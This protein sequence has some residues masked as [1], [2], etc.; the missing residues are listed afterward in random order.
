MDHMADQDGPQLSM[1]P[2][3]ACKLNSLQLKDLYLLSFHFEYMTSLHAYLSPQCLLPKLKFTTA[4]SKLA[5]VFF[6]TKGNI[7]RLFT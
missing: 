2:I 3:I 4:V 7:G 6:H 1:H 5:R